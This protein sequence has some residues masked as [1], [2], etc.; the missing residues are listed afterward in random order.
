MYLF[1]LE[2]SPFPGIC[3]EVGLQGHMVVLFSDFKGPSILFSKVAIPIHISDNSVGGFLFSTP[4]PA[5]IICRLPDNGH[6]DHC[7]VISITLI[8]CDVEHLFMC[9]LAIYMSSL[10]KR[11]FRSLRYFFFLN[12]WA[13]KN[14]D[15]VCSIMWL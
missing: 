7:E 1:K 3:P 11:L 4:S 6:S 8:I 14:S 9:S 12:K 5:F 15:S 2:F 13:Q 10:E